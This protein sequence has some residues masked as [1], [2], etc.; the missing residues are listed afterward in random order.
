[1]SVRMGTTLTPITSACRVRTGVRY[2]KVQ[3]CAQ[4]VSYFRPLTLTVVA[5]VPKALTSKS[6]LKGLGTAPHA[7]H[8]ARPVPTQPSAPHASILSHSMPTG[9]AHAPPS[10]S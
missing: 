1:M 8:T 3:L 7:A 6:Q 10:M 2:A 9:L 4:T 5:R